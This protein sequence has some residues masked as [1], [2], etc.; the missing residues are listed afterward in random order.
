MKKA[1]TTLLTVGLGLAVLLDPTTLPAQEEEAEERPRER[2][3]W[4]P[5]QA[6]ARMA[7]RLKNA[8]EVTDEEWEAIQPLV[9][10]VVVKQRQAG[11]GR[12][13]WGGRG[14]GGAGP[15]ERGRRGG[16]RDGEERGPRGQRGGMG[17]GSPELQ[18]LREAVTDE[19]TSPEALRERME[20][21]RQAQ[22]RAQAELKESRDQL[23]QVL[24]TRQ[25]ATLMMIGL[26]D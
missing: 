26:L 2:R 17:G 13:G 6:Q 1:M 18:A 7:E 10:D 12:M 24:T 5:E 25:E 3:E 14:R 23:R 15:E 9:E 21:V 19:N 20:A 8:L 11:G 22:A 16:E 4:N